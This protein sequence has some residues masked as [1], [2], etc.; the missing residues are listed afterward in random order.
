MRTFPFTAAAACAAL[1]AALNAHAQTSS[2][3]AAASGSSAPMRVLVGFS[4]GGPTDVVARAWAE[5]AARALGRSVIVEN[6]AGANTIVAAEAAAR[7]APDGLTLL[8]AATNHT[9]LPALYAQR[10]KFDPLADFEPICTVATSPTVLV[11]APKMAA[12]DVRG[13]VQ[14]ISQQAGTFTYASAGAGSSG[15]F[16]SEA[17]LQR[18]G[19][20]MT[21]IPYKG[22]AQ[23]L[24]DVM[25]GTVDASFATL[26][27]V[28]AHVQGGKLRALA[29]AAD[30]RVPDLPQVPTFDEAQVA[31]GYRAD[32][33]WGVLAPK[34]TAQS[35]LAAL[36]KVARS[37]THDAASVQRLRS[38]GMQPS[39][40]CG[41]AFAQ[42]MQTEVATYRTMAQQ[43]RLEID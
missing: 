41:A 3:H 40:V 21:H 12:A 33:W 42:Q 36:Q 6:R 7:A 27:S 5:H 4:A 10:L 28:L 31:V 35:T 1:L 39:A 32:V 25:S 37:F 38:L 16:A 26:G 29:V 23:A 17:F 19:A 15:H 11:T 18:V 13:F 2:S 14:A 34:G 22:A 20:R 43:L 24:T 30:A 9:M 8:F